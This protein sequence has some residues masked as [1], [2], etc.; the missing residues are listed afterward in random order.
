MD[1]YLYGLFYSLGRIIYTN[2]ESLSL[3]Y[4]ATGTSEI[5]VQESN[6]SRIRKRNINL[7]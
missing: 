6:M 5:L 1:K 2:L 7:D 4:K 3:F